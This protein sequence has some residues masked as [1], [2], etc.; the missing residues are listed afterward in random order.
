MFLSSLLPLVTPS[1]HVLLAALDERSNE[2]VAVEEA[3][4]IARDLFDNEAETPQLLV[5]DVNLRPTGD[6]D[7]RDERE[8]REEA[9][10][11]RAALVR[12]NHARHGL[13]HV[14]RIHIAALSVRLAVEQQHLPP[15]MRRD[16]LP[17]PRQEE[18]RHNRGP[19]RAHS[20]HDEL[21]LLHLL[22]HDGVDDRRDLKLL[23]LRTP[24]PLSGGE[25]E[26]Y[27]IVKGMVDA[28]YMISLANDLHL[29][30]VS[31]AP[32]DSAAA[33]GAAKRIGT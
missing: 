26:W 7:V 12:C 29:E 20:I 24:I 23:S 5:V 19:E 14:L 28:L 27:N 31:E 13:D 16:R 18:A 11:R 4:V 25:S 17:R 10:P 9:V 1:P 32:G 21:R 2:S 22:Q 15:L 33:R 6:E 8:E 30:D 3:H